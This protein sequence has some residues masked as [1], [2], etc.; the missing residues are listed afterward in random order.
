MDLN[1]YLEYKNIKK[2]VFIAFKKHFD[3]IIGHIKM[4]FLDMLMVLES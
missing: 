4:K 3:F 2:Y 1:L